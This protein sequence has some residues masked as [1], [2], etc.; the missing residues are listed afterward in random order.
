MPLIA[1]ER[2]GQDDELSHDRLKRAA[3]KAGMYRA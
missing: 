2:I 3:T 1:Q